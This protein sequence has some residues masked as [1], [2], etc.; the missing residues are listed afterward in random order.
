MIT[1]AAEADK[2]HFRLL[3]CVD[4]SVLSTAGPTS[5]HRKAKPELL[6]KKLITVHC[7]KGYLDK[8]WLEDVWW[9]VES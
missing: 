8:E 7:F 4:R 6:G 1:A 5:S 2:Q 9:K 3:R